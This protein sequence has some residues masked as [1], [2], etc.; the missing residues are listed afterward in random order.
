MANM[1]ECAVAIS[2][3]DI[4]KLGGAIRKAEENEK[5]EYIYTQDYGDGYYT[6]SDGEVRLYCY[7]DMV[8]RGW[9]EVND[10][11]EELG[12]CIGDHRVI[13]DTTVDNGWLVDWQLLGTYS[14][15]MM[16]Y[17]TEHSEHIVVWFGGRWCFPEALENKLDALEVHWQGAVVEDGN[18][19]TY[20]DL[21]NEDYGLE[22]VEEEDEPWGEGEDVYYYHYINDGASK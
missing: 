20:D 21:G 18:E 16:P 3:A 5:S 9:R 11:L 14:Y 17:I 15:D 8:A 12:K 6:V 2:K 4:E 13:K 22:I 1:A 7:G 19:I 10:K